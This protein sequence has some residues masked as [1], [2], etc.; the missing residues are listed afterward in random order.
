MK[1]NKLNT[2]CRR[3]VICI[4]SHVLRHSGGVKV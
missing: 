2:Y 3:D 1:S 4:Q